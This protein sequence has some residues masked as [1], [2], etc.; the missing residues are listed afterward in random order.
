M[1]KIGLR[2]GN[3]LLPPL[4]RFPGA[5][6]ISIKFW[7]FMTTELSSVH[8]RFFTRSEQSIKKTNQMSAP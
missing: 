7:S 2:H 3:L 5:K 1:K 8:R 4:P 6:V